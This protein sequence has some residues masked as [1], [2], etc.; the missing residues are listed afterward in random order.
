MLTNNKGFTLI[1]I[2]VTIAILSIVIVPLS[3]MFIQAAKMNSMAAEEYDAT[4]IAQKYF[5]EIKSIKSDI[6]AASLNYIFDANNDSFSK[7]II[8]GKFTIAINMVAVA[9]TQNLNNDDSEQAL[10]DGNNMKISF[11]EEN[12]IMTVVSSKD[13]LTES[14]VGIS[15]TFSINNNT[16]SQYELYCNGNS[17]EFKGSS[18]QSTGIIDTSDFSQYNIAIIMSSDLN[19]NVYNKIDGTAVKITAIKLAGDTHNFNLVGKEGIVEQ[20][21]NVIQGNIESLSKSILYDVSIVVKRNGNEVTT[22]VGK[23]AFTK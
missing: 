20:K 5:E 22:F 2:I 19:M 9:G 8:D 7:D 18:M 15:K 10:I 13:S 3:S 6:D 23:K 11:N 21:V 1:E 16:P 12:T 14:N 17:L 4:L